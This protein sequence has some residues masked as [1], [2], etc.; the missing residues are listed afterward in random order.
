[1]T[2]GAYFFILISDGRTQ[3][4][5][6]APKPLSNSSMTLILNSVKYKLLIYTI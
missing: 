1:M 4:C 2:V 3:C 6:N 5:I